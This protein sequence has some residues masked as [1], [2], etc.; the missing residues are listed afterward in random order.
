MN[1]H[2]NQRY[3]RSGCRNAGRLSA[4]TRGP[5]TIEIAH[6]ANRRMASKP[7]I[8]TNSTRKSGDFRW[9]VALV[10]WAFGLAW[11]AG[12]LAL[13]S[14]LER[15]ARAEHE[16][17]GPA[18]V[19]CMAC[20]RLRR[21]PAAQGHADGLETELA[22]L[23][24]GLADLTAARTGRRRRPWREPVDLEPLARSAVAGWRHALEAS[25]RAGRVEWRAGAPRVVADRGRLAQALGNLVAN[26]AEHG[27]GPVEL[28]SRRTPGGVRV[29]VRNGRARAD[30][31]PSGPHAP[32]ADRGRGL[33]IAATAA[34][35]AGGHLELVPDRDDVVAAIELPVDD[36][37]AGPDA[38]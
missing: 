18:T 9:C 2:T 23:R 5:S 12:A 30:E 11:M 24:A 10:G 8:T 19:L 35:S 21:D 15:V 4:P 36:A 25:G 17:R 14:R 26:A 3:L 6:R 38:A 28:R 22:R 7:M 31:A 16:L 32:P 13:R 37:P 33:Q 34:R 20:E 1:A 29:E 27:S